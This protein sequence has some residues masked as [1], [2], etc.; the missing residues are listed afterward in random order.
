MVFTGGA[1]ATTTRDTQ[2]AIVVGGDVHEIR[3][4]A[5]FNPVSMVVK[6]HDSDLQGANATDVIVLVQGLGMCGPSD[7]L[8]VAYAGM[9]D[10]AVAELPLE[11]RMLGTLRV[12]MWVGEREV[13]FEVGELRGR[14]WGGEVPGCEREKADPGLPA[15]GALREYPKVPR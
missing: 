5:L 4:N 13:G 12:R 6:V 15:L 8:T 14:R 7:G 9:L 3:S 10:G 2:R 11:N 1:W